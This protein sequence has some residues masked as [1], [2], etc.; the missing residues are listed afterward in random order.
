MGRN[1]YA[2]ACRIA[3][4]AVAVLTMWCTDWP[5]TFERIDA[6]QLRL[7][8]FCYVNLS[9]TTARLCDFAPGDSVLLIAYFSGKPLE[10]IEWDVSWN[11]QID[12][13]GAD[14]AFD[15]EPLDYDVVTIDT[16]LFT[17]ST[18]IA[19]IRFMIPDD[20]MMN[21]VGTDDGS[22]AELGLG[23]I[24]AAELLGLVDYY[25]RLTPLERENDS[26]IAPIL[27]LIQAYAPILTQTLSVP[28]RIFATANDVY[29]IKSDLMV[30]YNRLLRDHPGVYV[31][32]NPEIHFVGVHKVRGPAPGVFRVRDMDLGDTTYCLFTTES[33]AS[34]TASRLRSA[35]V[36]GPAVL[37][38]DT[39]TIDTGFVYYIAVDSGVYA[40]VDQRDTGVAIDYNTA[41]GEIGIGTPS[42]E[43][44]FTMFFHQF[45][46]T[47]IAGI[48]NLDLMITGATGS[49][50]EYLLPPLDTAVTRAH[51]WVQLSDYFLGERNRPIAS[52]LVE[53]ELHFQYTPGYADSVATLP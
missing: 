4:A 49:P 40:G 41:Q 28:A 2:R 3:V 35:G 34:R 9:D 52:S 43:T 16:S 36:A 46:P 13:Y 26:L 51:L 27:P 38:S 50:T 37:F 12:L 5:T 44:Y 30:R 15:R 6:D 20:I 33:S 45:D 22:L 24:D 23:D 1:M 53:T 21:S 7:L 25:A 19:A 47:E 14:T 18:D 10:S 29:K 39:V 32:R 8:D 48:D 17:D 11:V 31:N 42:P